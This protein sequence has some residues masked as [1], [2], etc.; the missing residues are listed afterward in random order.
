[1]FNQ[2]QLLVHALILKTIDTAINYSTTA[3]GIAFGALQQYLNLNNM[4]CHWDIQ[5]DT[6]SQLFANNNFHPKTTV[7][8][9]NAFSH[10]GRGNWNSSR[11][12]AVQGIEWCK[13]PWE[14]VPNSYLKSIN[15]EMKGLT[16]TSEKTK[17]NDPVNQ[18]A[19]IN[20]GTTTE[21]SQY[22]ERTFDLIVTDPP[23]GGYFITLNYQIFSTYGLD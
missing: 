19:Q 4:F 6:T 2:R 7:V 9:N 22:D 11:K 18:V 8:E 10:I 16:G 1:M 23:F 15:S 3:K 14:L 17:P 13:S 21:L 5:R 20:C 12:S